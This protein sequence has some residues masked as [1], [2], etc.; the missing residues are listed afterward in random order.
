[1]KAKQSRHRRFPPSDHPTLE[2][3]RRRSSVSERLLF[4]PPRPQVSTRRTLHLARHPHGKIEAANALPVAVSDVPLA[5]LHGVERTVTE[6]DQ[7]QEPRNVVPAEKVARQRR[8]V[9][10][11]RPPVAVPVAEWAHEA[12]R[13]PRQ[14]P[15]RSDRVMGGVIP[16][17]A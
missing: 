15:Q 3:I 2:L 5:L 17:R 7:A 10:V 16:T 12:P 13:E 6:P 4:R 14:V 8:H 9:A 1:T 11:D